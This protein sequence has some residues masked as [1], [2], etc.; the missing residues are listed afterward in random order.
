MSGFGISLPISIP[1]P[2]RGA[3]VARLQRLI[4]PPQISIPAPARGAT[5]QCDHQAGDGPISIPAPA[6]G[7][8]SPMDDKRFNRIDFNSRPCE[9]GD[10]FDGV[11]FPTGIISIPA[12]ARGATWGFSARYKSS[13][14]FQF[15][16]LREGRR[17]SGAVRPTAA[18]F[19]FPPL[20]EGRRD[21]DGCNGHPH[22][23][24]SRPC[25][26]GDPTTTRRN[27]LAILFQF[28]PVRQGGRSCPK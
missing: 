20:R 27:A 18:L 17:R 22:H 4:P 15:P 12:P 13:S 3:T 5:P 1:A 24:N 2:A 7:A 8:T 23:F 10:L 19:Q 26:R 11:D 25:E 28:P 21:G 6:R 9:R 16:P 14:S